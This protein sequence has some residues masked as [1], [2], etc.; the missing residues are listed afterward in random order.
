MTVGLLTRC[1]EI[2]RRIT[3]AAMADKRDVHI[4]KSLSYLLRHGA[5]KE[6][7]P[8]DS[9][10]YVPLGRL[11]NHNRL[12]THRC[13]VE[14][15]HRIVQ[16][17]EKKRFH[18][19]STVNKNGVAEEYVCA[20][21]GHSINVITPDQEVLKQ[22]KD[23]SELP[24]KLVHGTSITKALLIVQ[25]GFISKQSRNH[26]HLA[27]GIT[28][29]DSQVISGMRNSSNVYIHLNVHETLLDSL[30][31]Y[32]SLNNVYL[33]SDDIPLSLFEKVVIKPPKMDHE[34]SKDTKALLELL[35]RSKVPY[36]LLD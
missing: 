5:I 32:K 21:Q 6:R 35:S 30:Q 27:P 18:L 28:G 3:A 31:L 33:T 24:E 4:S 8:I 1:F 34:V 17:N 14:D 29:V 19:K 20:T 15:I 13:S 26:I 7:L 2:R 36:Q 9:N 25:S 11:L 22:I 23:T 10:G 16:N 12:K